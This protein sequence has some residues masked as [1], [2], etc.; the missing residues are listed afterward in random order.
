MRG[1]LG[2]WRVPGWWGRAAVAVV[3][4]L[5][6]G[7]VSVPAAQAIS[8]DTEVA[9][10]A[11]NGDLFLLFGGDTGFGMMRGTSPSV[12]PYA[13]GIPPPLDNHQVAFQANTGNLWVLG[14]QS[15]G[16]SGLGMNRG[17]SPSLDKF[18]VAFQANTGNLFAIG[19]CC[20]GGGDTGVAMMS[21]TSPSINGNGDFAFQD[22]GNDLQLRVSAMLSSPWGRVPV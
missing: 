1:L 12:D 4:A 13:I 6:A 2:G 18:N 14:P 19:P 7:C 16:D 8:L 11:N 22:T 21:G 15:P 5:A 10:Q 17:A 3:V 9:F 20:P